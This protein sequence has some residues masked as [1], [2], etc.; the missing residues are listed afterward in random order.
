LFHHFEFR[1]EPNTGWFRMTD[2][3]NQTRTQKYKEPGESADLLDDAPL[4]DDLLDTACPHALH[5]LSA[6]EEAAIDERLSNADP[7]T[8]KRFAD[9]TREVGETMA[10][11]SATT[12]VAPPSQLRDNLLSA[13]VDTPQDPPDPAAP[14]TA[15]RNR[16]HRLRW[17]FLAAAAVA[18]VAGGGYAAT[19]LP[20]GFHSGAPAHLG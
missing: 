13:I 14:D 5:A 1:P 4:D 3:V 2:S 12:A 20:D 18:A 17:L 7:Q 16:S 10:L 11:L 15:P 19:H 9:L 6:S 8:R